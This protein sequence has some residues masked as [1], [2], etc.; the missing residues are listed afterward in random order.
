MLHTKMVVITGGPGAGKTSVTKELRKHYPVA[1][2]SARLVLTR[3]RLFKHKNAKQAAGK[4]F[5]EAI[6]DIEV[7][8]YARAL[9]LKGAAYIFFDRGFFD[10]FAYCQLAHVKHLEERIAQGRHMVYDAVFIL[11]PLPHHFYE[12]DT[13]RA[14]SYEEALKIHE[15]IIGMYCKYGYKPILVPFSTVKKRAAFILRKLK[16]LPRER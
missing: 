15:L 10:G 13:K 14:E 16:K 1:R 6:W 3:N 4:K 5:Q 12:T 11:E 8:H 2:E 9:T 7:R